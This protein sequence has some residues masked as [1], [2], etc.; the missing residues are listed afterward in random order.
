[1]KTKKK[2]LQQKWNN[3]FPPI[4]VQTCAQM[5]TKVKLLGGDTDEDHTQIVGGNTVKLLRGI[6]PPSPPGFSTPACSGLRPTQHPL[7]RH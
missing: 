7:P 6:Y 2:G 1:M 3:F 5:H 4:Q